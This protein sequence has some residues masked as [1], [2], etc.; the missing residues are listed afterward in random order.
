[1]TKEMSRDKKGK[2]KTITLNP[3]SFKDAV[4]AALATP[5]ERKPKKTSHVKSQSPP[6]KAG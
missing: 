3:V 5:A 2:G 1:M 6:K 4:A